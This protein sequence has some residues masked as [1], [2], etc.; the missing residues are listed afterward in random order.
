MFNNE[1]VQEMGKLRG[2]ALRLTDQPSDA[3]DLLQ[4]S[5]LKAMEKQDKFQLGSNIFAWCSKIMY[6]TFVS[7]YRRRKKHESQYDPEPII[8]AQE[9][10]DRQL[11]QLWCA[12]VDA[13]MQSLSSDHQRILESVCVEGQQYQEVA[14]K[15]DIPVGTVRSRLSRARTALEKTLE[16][17]S[18]PEIIH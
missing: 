7:G 5:L 17:D 18:K 11:E 14:S 15:L 3:D 8:A 2:F 9:T 12:E 1:L 13:A 6:N 4:A 10:P 16:N